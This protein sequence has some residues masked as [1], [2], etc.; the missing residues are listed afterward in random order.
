MKKVIHITTIK[1]GG[2]GLS[3][4]GEEADTLGSDA[5]P[6]LVSAQTEQGRLHYRYLTKGSIP[7]TPT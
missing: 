6:V 2:S 1:Y 7:F 5:P 3:E 4:C